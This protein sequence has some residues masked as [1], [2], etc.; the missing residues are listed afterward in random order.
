MK[1]CSV[2]LC[3]HEILIKS[4]CSVNGIFPASFHSWRNGYLLL[5]I[6]PAI[7]SNDRAVM[8][9]ESDGVNMLRSVFFTG[10]LTYIHHA[11]AFHVRCSCI[12]DMSVM[13]PYNSFSAIFVVRLNIF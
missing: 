9:S 13:L 5:R 3:E 2:F 8:S 11:A 1:K 12:S 4:T 6:T 7:R 10:K